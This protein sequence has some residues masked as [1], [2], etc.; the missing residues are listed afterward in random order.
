MRF[1]RHDL[2]DYDMLNFLN[3]KIFVKTDGYEITDIF[4]IAINGAVCI[5]FL[6]QKYD[7]KNFIFFKVNFKKELPVYIKI[8]ICTF[9]QA[10]G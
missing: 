6:L 2:H 5:L 3:M 10:R 7:N 8:F 1:L 4:E 9:L